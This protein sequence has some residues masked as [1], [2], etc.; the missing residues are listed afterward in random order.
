MIMTRLNTYD[1]EKFKTTIKES[2]DNID[3]ILYGKNGFE[4]IVKEDAKKLGR[5]KKEDDDWELQKK[6]EE[7]NEK[8][9]DKEDKEDKK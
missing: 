3:F 7:E 1:F 9:D 2:A 5:D 6:L 4:V 8:D